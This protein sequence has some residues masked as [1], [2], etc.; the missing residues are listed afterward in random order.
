MS[1]D[2]NKAIKQISNILEKDELP[3]NVKQLIG[4]FTNST[5]DKK[6]ATEKNSEPD[7]N[8]QTEERQNNDDELDNNIAMLSKIGTLMSRMKN[9]K[10][11]RVNL[12]TSIKPFLNKR[13]K[14]KLNSC[15]NFLRLY[16]I[17]QNLL[18]DNDNNTG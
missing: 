11:P 15:I 3:D 10:D 14:T 2:L 16:P 9:Y 17:I 5:N 13:R 7:K 18:E 4:A 8:V 6:S 12:L 1:D